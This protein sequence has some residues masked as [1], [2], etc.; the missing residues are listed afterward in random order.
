MVDPSWVIANG[1]R[2]EHTL[3]LSHKKIKQTKG[4]EEKGLAA[5]TQTY[6]NTAAPPQQKHS[7]V[8]P[9]PPALFLSPPRPVW[10]TALH[11]RQPAA[12][13]NQPYPVP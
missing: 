9:M 6:H 4:D 8:A 10:S 13:L 3:E 2:N 5:T 7:T 12:M 11:S 1:E